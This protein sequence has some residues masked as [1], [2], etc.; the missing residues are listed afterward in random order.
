MGLCYTGFF[1]V[2]WNKHK[3][4][5]PFFFFFF[6]LPVPYTPAEERKGFIQIGHFWPWGTEG[7]SIYTLLRRL[8]TAC[9]IAC[10]HL[11]LPAVLT[12]VPKERQ[13]DYSLFCG[14]ILVCCRCTAHCNLLCA[15]RCGS[16]QWGSGNRKHSQKHCHYFWRKLIW[17]VEKPSSTVKK[18]SFCQPW[19]SSR[20]LPPC[21]VK[22]SQLSVFRT[23]QTNGSAVCYQEVVNWIWHCTPP[24]SCTQIFDTSKKSR[25][26]IL[27]IALWMFLSQGGIV[28]YLEG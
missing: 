25:I 22:A 4:V 12:S 3:K 19:A 10:Q 11:I 1:F 13:C 9:S 20:K 18:Q 2:V 6:L 23:L 8:E 27:F 16:S 15:F 7:D 14:V 28:P 17:W 21:F 26:F 5:S 24:Y